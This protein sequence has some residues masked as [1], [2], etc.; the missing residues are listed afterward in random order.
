MET[1]AV[2]V[3]ALLA[4]KKKT[5]VA[6]SRPAPTIKGS[7]GFTENF[8]HWNGQ[9]VP[10]DV[11]EFLSGKHAHTDNHDW[12]SRLFRCARWC[13]DHQVP[14]E[15]AEQCLVAGADPDDTAEEEKAM[16]TIRSAHSYTPPAAQG[17]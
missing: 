6:V 16:N 8:S 14:Q 15:V 4:S 2:I 13:R 1:P 11:A 17:N 3:E 9:R 5:P 12:N 7:G 10:A